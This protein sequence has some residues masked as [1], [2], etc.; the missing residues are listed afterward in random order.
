LCDVGLIKNQ[1]HWQK[2]LLCGA[3]LSGFTRCAKLPL[4]LQRRRP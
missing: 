2:L 4:G 3:G 1:A